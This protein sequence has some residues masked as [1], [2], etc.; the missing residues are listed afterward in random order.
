MINTVIFDLDGTILDT[1]YDLKEAVN[2]ALRTLNY[3]ERTLPEIRE[4]IG[5][6]LTNLMLRS[7]GKSIVDEEVLESI[8]LFTL[9]YKEHLDVYTKEFEGI[10]GLLIELK[11]NGFKI[12]VLSNKDDYAVKLLCDKF[13][14][15]LIDV[16]RG[17]TEDGKVKP[18][19]S[20]INY[21]YEQLNTHN[22]I[23][24]GDSTTDAKTIIEN[25]LNGIL[26][27][28]G[29]DDYEDLAEYSICVVNSITELKKQIIKQNFW[30]I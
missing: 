1:I 3:K 13:Y 23:Y 14:P 2:F 11:A 28:W 20:L 9:Y 29:Y 27:T 15:G 19:A 24:V 10:K 26:V 8:K 16:K 4:F 6:G 17:R 25:N 21:M 22:V 5:D 30:L 12:G 7:L 18:D